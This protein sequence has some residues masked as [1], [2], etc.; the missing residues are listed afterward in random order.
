MR[1]S[2]GR[3]FA[4]R[5]ALVLV[6][7]SGCSETPLPGTN[8]GTYHVTG[9]TTSN[10][11]GA[12]LNPPDPW[13]FNAELSLDGQNVYWSW[14][15]GTAPLS[16]PIKSTTATLSTN[17]TAN[18][19]ATDAGAGPCTLARADTLQVTFASGSPPA[20]FEGTLTYSFSVPSGSTCTDQLSA[21]GG[22]YDT[23]PCTMAYTLSGAHQ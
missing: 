5:C 22:L 17:N 21:N 23:L 6:A 13:V 8:Y 19:D 20:T 16:G 15:D 2:A 10:T 3:S 14:M 4:L 11:C 12:G 9:S 18:V 7:G 1:V